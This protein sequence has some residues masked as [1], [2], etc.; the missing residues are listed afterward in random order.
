MKKPSNRE[1]RVKFILS[2]QGTDNPLNIISHQI[3]SFLII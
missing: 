1:E 3:V 2:K